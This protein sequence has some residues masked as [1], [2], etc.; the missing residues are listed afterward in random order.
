[1]YV[2]AYASGGGRRREAHRERRLRRHVRRRAGSQRG[3]DGRLRSRRRRRSSRAET[4]PPSSSRAGVVGSSIRWPMFSAASADGGATFAPTYDLYSV[5][6]PS[7][8]SQFLRNSWRLPDD[9]IRAQ[10]DSIY[11]DHPSVRPVVRTGRLRQQRAVGGVHE[12]GLRRDF[13]CAGDIHAQSGQGRRECQ[14][15][16]RGRSGSGICG[17]RRRYLL[18]RLPGVPAGGIHR[19]CSGARGWSGPCGDRGPGDVG[20]SGLLG[21]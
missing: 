4:V 15:G 13:R 16:S 2:A 20:H 8:P 18:D 1:M 14:G 9:S 19:Q 10:G 6:S 12:H 3:L 21:R 5:L 7:D 17:C 11:V